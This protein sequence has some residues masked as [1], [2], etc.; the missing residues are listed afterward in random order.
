MRRRAPTSISELALTT[1]PAHT[2]DVNAQEGRS[3]AGADVE[4][5]VQGQQ[6]PGP[7][8]R[9]SPA[10]EPED[11]DDTEWPLLGGRNQQRGQAAAPVRP[12][13]VWGGIQKI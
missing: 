13:G 6:E 1:A 3:S 7:Q 2:R 5:T 8:L 12:Q 9:N 4:N 10:P 11:L